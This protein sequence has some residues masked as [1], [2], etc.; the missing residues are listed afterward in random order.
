ME[1][2]EPGYVCPTCGYD[3]RGLRIG[4]RGRPCPECGSRVRPGRWPVPWPGWWRV[5]AGMVGPCWLGLGALLTLMLVLPRPT[6]YAM[7]FTAFTPIVV[8]VIVAVELP[9]R[10]GR[11]FGLEGPRLDGPPRA[12]SIAL[13]GLAINAVG[14]V[15]F[16][17]VAWA[18]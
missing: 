17:L 5:C 4:P 8:L 2:P 7:V 14:V 15:L 11:R 3:L 13:L 12:R 6:W 18:A 16:G 1:P 9:L 10:S